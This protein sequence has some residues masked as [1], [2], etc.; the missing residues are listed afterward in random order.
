MTTEWFAP[1]GAGIGAVVQATL[2]KALALYQGTPHASAWVHHHLRRLEAPLS[3]AI[4]GPRQAGKSTLLNALAGAELAATGTGTGIPVATWYTD[5]P[6]AQALAYSSDGSALEL[7]MSSPGTGLGVVNGP[8]VPAETER[9]MIEWPARSLRGIALIDT[10]GVDAPAASGPGWPR[11]MRTVAEADAVVYVTPRPRPSDVEFLEALHGSHLARANPVNVVVV[12]S[13]A[14]EMGAGT[15]EAMVTARRIARQHLRDSGLAALCQHILPVAGLLSEGARTLQ[16]PDFAALA[17][18]AGVEQN[19][20]SA[21]LVS[22]DRLAAAATPSVS[23]EARTRLLR[24]FGLYG[25]RLATTLIRR[26]FDTTRSLSAELT[27]RGGLVEL[28]E[29]ISQLFT[30]GQDVLKARSALLGLETVLRSDPQPGTRDL[31]LEV[32]RLLADAHEF[33]ELRLLAALRA[34]RTGLP[35]DLVEEAVQLTGGHGSSPGER[36]GS[37]SGDDELIEIAEG[38]LEQWRHYAENPLAAQSARQAAQ[39][40]VRSCE[41]LIAALAP[42]LA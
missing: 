35:G 18:L 19:A 34:G 26:G 13:R 12:F 25:I 23:A 16:E 30:G 27:Q 40:V 1:P 24:R 6:T 33:R 17:G 41:G 14:D 5:G 15:V 3:V 9:V 10:P 7:P 42:G 31:F 22:A 36:L 38:A 21:I 4:V 32:R 11:L 20:L 2:R 29:T 28:R 39:T 37:E 8:D